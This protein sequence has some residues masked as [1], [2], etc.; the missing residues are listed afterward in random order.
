MSRTGTTGLAR[1]TIAAP[2]RRVDV[3]LPESATAAE[4]LPSLLRVAGDGLA[5]SGQ[6]HGGWALRRTDGSM[7]D[8]GKSIGANELRDG[9]IL[10]LVPRQAE[11]PEM[12]YDDTVDAIATNALKQSRSWGPSATRRAGLIFAAIGLTLALA[13]LVVSGPPWLLPGSISLGLAAV[14]LAAGVT[15]SRAVADSGTGATLG[16]LAMLLAAFGG[17]AFLQGEQS[18]LA[19]EPAQYVAAGAALVI[20][21]FLGFLG[22]GDRTQYF[23][24]GMFLGLFVA[25]GGLVA[26][27]EW[28]GLVGI[29]AGA[30]AVVVLFT[31]IFPLLSIRLSKLPMPNLP[32]SAEDLL[33]DPPQVPLP[34]IHATVRRADE[35]LT[36]LQT[37]AAA[38]VV[39]ASVILVA[40]ADRS[41]AILVGI[42]SLAGL[43][44]ARLFPALRH[45]LPLLVAGGVGPFLLAVAAIV[46]YPEYR[47]PIIV[48]ALV[49]IAAIC[50]A[51]GLLYQNRPPSPYFGRIADILDILVILGVVPL[52][53][54]VLGLFGYF[55]G[56]A[57]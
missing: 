19:A 12:D 25:L 48:P 23:V 4:V 20:T 18:L 40:D 55:R 7:L 2:N 27:A 36:G 11:W 21:A 28:T 41:A 10:H 3:A 49:V 15:A 13:V 9:D 34:R 39:L 53:C 8:P 26:L 6:T 42:V 33:K 16:G 31:P 14:V 56:L 51:A 17:L 22:V 24:A 50:L 54:L 1:V 5:D 45:R 30:A 44:R 52:T 35:I 38:I 57:G 47:L 43:L 46:V 29:A 37:G 32:T